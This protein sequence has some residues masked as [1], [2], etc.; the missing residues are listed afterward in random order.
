MLSESARMSSAAEARF[1]MP[2]PASVSRVVK[3]VALD[4][5]CDH[6]VERLAEGSWSGVTFFPASAVADRAAPLVEDIATGDLVVMVAAVGADASRAALIG[7][8]CSDRRVHTATFVVRA[9]SASDEALS[10]TLAQVRPWSLMVV[11]VGDDNY[12]EDILRS[13][14]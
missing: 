13:F 1:R 14:R 9:A 6:V 2:A 5:A 7:K 8:A 4:R 3:V 12:V 10:K 11:I